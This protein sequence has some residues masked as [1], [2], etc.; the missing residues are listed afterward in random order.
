MRRMGERGRSPWREEATDDNANVAIGPYF[1][2]WD[3]TGI[4]QFTVPGDGLGME[5]ID[6]TQANWV[7]AYALVAIMCH[8]AAETA[9]GS[10][11]EI[12]PPDH[13]A[14]ANYVA[15]MHLPQE[16][17][18]YD[19]VGLDRFPRVKESDQGTALLPLT[20]CRRNEYESV[21][22]FLAN[23][24]RRHV[25][26]EALNAVYEGVNELGANVVEHSQSDGAFLA[27][28]TYR[29]GQSNEEIVFAVG[30][31]GVGIR[32][33]LEARY[34]IQSDAQALQLAVTEGV[35]GVDDPAR[36]IGLASVVESARMLR[37]SSVVRSGS[38]ALLLFQ[39]GTTPIVVGDQLGTTVG[40]KIRSRPGA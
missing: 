7:D 30:D 24:L 5:V 20:V 11:V 16:L 32:S 36:G 1:G 40:A 4:D 13:Q 12:Y 25:D 10:Q 29:R 6:M 19:V 14:V 34:S 35:S 39:H 33:S 27:A 8:V 9:F 21:S 37:G 15:R 26:P 2:S 31:V 38:A 22:E 18:P 23:R 17:A 3:M 28:Q